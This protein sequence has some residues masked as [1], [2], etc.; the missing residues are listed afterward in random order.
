M[1]E[2]E[3]EAVKRPIFLPPLSPPS[4]TWSV[5]PLQPKPGTVKPW[6][7]QPAVAVSKLPFWK[8]ASAHQVR[9]AGVASVP[10]T[11]VARASSRCEPFATS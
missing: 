6:L 5:P 7:V 1:G 4:T 8:L 3:P 9:T 10:C 11:E 2:P